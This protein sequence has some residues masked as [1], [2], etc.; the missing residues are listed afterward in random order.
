MEDLEAEFGAVVEQFQVRFHG[1]QVRGGDRADLPQERVVVGEEG[2]EEPKE[3]G[4]CWW[5]KVLVSWRI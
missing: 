3:E 5:N 2:E 4:R 1:V